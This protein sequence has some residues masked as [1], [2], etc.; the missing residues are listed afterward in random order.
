ML[1]DLPLDMLVCRLHSL[2]TGDRGAVDTPELDPHLAQE[3]GLN[4]RRLHHCSQIR[5]VQNL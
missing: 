1:S 5:G 2:Q 3:L 4:K